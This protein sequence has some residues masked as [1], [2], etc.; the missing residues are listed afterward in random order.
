MRERC[1]PGSLSPPPR[2]PGHEA[3]VTHAFIEGGPGVQHHTT[4]RMNVGKGLPQACTCKSHKL[5]LNYQVLGPNID[6]NGY[7]PSLRNNTR[8]T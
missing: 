6:R 7:V 8:V 3:N 5:S 2:E 4:M 1:V